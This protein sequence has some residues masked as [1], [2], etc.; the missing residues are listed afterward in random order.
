MD[1]V[2]L[3]SFLLIAV[4]ALFL[5]QP[6][7]VTALL[8]FSVPL[9]A[10]AWFSQLRAR[11]RAK[12]GS[13]AIALTVLWGFAAA[14]AFLVIWQALLLS[15]DNWK[16]SRTPGPGGGRRGNGHAPWRQRHHGRLRGGP[17]WHHHHHLRRR[18][19]WMIACTLIAAALYVV[20]VFMYQGRFR[21]FTT[22]SWYQ[23]PY[24]L[25]ALVPLF[26]I[27]LASV[28]ADGLVSAVRGWLGRMTERRP[29][30]RRLGL[31]QFRDP[32]AC[33]P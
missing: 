22:G 21:H 14:A 1:N 26:T 30:G 13:R 24:R 7:G 3:W 11:I 32:E 28:G 18:G 23:D 10:A 33:T 9:I 17:P 8:A 4:A 2:S 20:A 29:A 31:P 6:N 25:A 27:V 5:S 16:P 15:F 12:A 19:G